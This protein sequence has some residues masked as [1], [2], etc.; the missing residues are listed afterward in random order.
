MLN[1][2]KTTTK[3]YKGIAGCV[4]A[5]IFGGLVIAVY[6]IALLAMGEDYGVSFVDVAGG[7]IFTAAMFIITA[8]IRLIGNVFHMT[9]II[10]VNVLLFL[11]FT[12]AF[13]AAIIGASYLISSAWG[14]DDSGTMGMLI[15][16]IVA[17]VLVLIHG[18][19]LIGR[20]VK[21]EKHY[22]QN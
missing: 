2:C 15:T 22:V 9:K 11:L 20:I 21:K 1:L 14:N 17:A 19:G 3:M 13:V 6:Y 7:M 4:V 5:L 16:G 18:T 8:V 12:T 10:V